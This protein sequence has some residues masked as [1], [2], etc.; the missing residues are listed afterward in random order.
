MRGPG[1]LAAGALFFVLAAGCA[2]APVEGRKIAVYG[3]EAATADV[4][5]LRLTARGFAMVDRAEV[6]RAS[7]DGRSRLGPAEVGR[8]V[9]AE[10]VAWGTPGAEGDVELKLVEVATANVLF[11]RTGRDVAELAD[12]LAGAVR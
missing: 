11:A 10:Y 1:G 4:I 6:A 3:L 12:A 7:K 2:S 8:L 9:G 5:H